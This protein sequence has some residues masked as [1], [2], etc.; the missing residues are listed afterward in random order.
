[1][2]KLI[3]FIICIAI[4]IIYP[5][6]IEKILAITRE[7]NNILIF[8]FALIIICSAIYLKKC[9]YHHGNTK[10]F[11]KPQEDKG[12][13]LVKVNEKLPI[14]KNIDYYREIPCNGDLIRTFWFLFQ[15]DLLRDETDIIG[16]FILKWKKEQ[17]INI[18]N[19][20]KIDLQNL[21]HSEN[22]LENR[23]IDLIKEASGE[24][25]II[26]AGE[27]QKWC[28]KNKNIEIWWKQAIRYQTKIFEKEGTVYECKAGVAISEELNKEAIQILGFKKFLLNYSL[29]HERMPIEVVNWEEYLIFAQVIGIAQEV[30][31]QFQVVYPEIEEIRKNDLNYISKTGFGRFFRSLIYAHSI[32]I[33]FFM[34]LGLNFLLWIWYG[35][36]TLITMIVNN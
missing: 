8:Q 20:Q 26:E 24:N 7:E 10:I 33:G 17:K 6:Q 27:I 1:M 21:T 29:I 3:V 31:K 36:A 16:A 13:K 11:F 35:L 15:Y 19:S 23:L 12:L 25:L 22:E 30:I 14:M 4:T 32:F 34:A 28:E 5:N 9:L 2:K 18:N